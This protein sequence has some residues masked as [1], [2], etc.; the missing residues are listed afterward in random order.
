VDTADVGERPE[1]IAGRYELEASIGRGAFG[2]VFRARDRETGALVALKRLRTSSTDPAA[3]ERFEREARLHSR[4]TSPRIVRC[5]GHGIEA[6]KQPYLVL[7]WLDG[8]DVGLRQRTRPLAWSEVVEVARQ[9]ALGLHA[10]HEEG[11]VHRDVKPQNLFVLHTAKGAPL[12]LKL[13]D[14]GIARVASDTPLTLDGQW[15]GTPHYMSPEQARGDVGLGP[16]ADV[17]ALGSVLYELLSGVRPFRAEDP[18]AVLAKILLEDPAPLTQ[19]APGLPAALAALVHRALAKAPNERFASALALAEALDDVA[20]AAPAASLTFVPTLVAENES[21]TVPLTLPW[22]S[23]H[24]ERR[25]VTAVF[26]RLDADA[27][28]G[29]IGE[30]AALATAHGAVAHKVLARRLIAIFGAQRTTGDEVLRA[31]RASLAMAAFGFAELAIVTG[32]VL[33]GE[34]ELSGDAI[35]RGARELERAG[36]GIRVDDATARLLAGR[37]VVEGEAG[38][39]TLLAGER[40]LRGA[41]APPVLGKKTPTVGRESVLA[42]IEGTYDECVADRVARVVLLT[43][44]AGLGK[45][46]VRLE[47]LGRLQRRLPAPTVLIARAD[48]LRRGSPLGLVG[49]AL[50]RLAGLVEGPPAA[51]RH[52]ALRARITR[53][54][55][56]HQHDRVA[57]L[58]GELAGA[59]LPGEGG[60]ALTAARADPT[61]MHDGKRAAWEDWLVAETTASPVVLILEDLHWADP[62]S[63]KFVD[64]AL[65]HLADRPFFVLALARPDVRSVFPELWSARGVTEVRL[66]PLNRR[67]SELLVRAVLGDDVRPE[68]VA[69]IVQRAEGNAFYLEELMRAVAHG[70]ERGLPETVLGMVQARIDELG[71]RAKRVL[72]AASVFGQTFWRG[73]IRALLGEV[74]PAAELDLDEHLAELAACEL[75]IERPASRFEGETELVFRHAL[76]REAAYA[77]L[78][79]EDRL[80]AHRL[81]GEWLEAAGEADATVLAEHFDAGGEP[82]RAATFYR[83]GAEQ[84]LEGHDFAA[85]LGCVERA[86]R[87]GAKG[88]ELATLRLAEAEARRWR[89]ELEEAARTALA[90]KEGLTPGTRRWFHALGE[91]VLSLGRI[92]RHEEVV[93][94]AEEA[95]AMG[96]SP[97]EQSA[98]LTCLSRAATTLLQVGEYERADAIVAQLDTLLAGQAS[99]DMGALAAAHQ[100]RFLHAMHRGDPAVGFAEQ[101]VVVGALDEAGDARNG[102]VAR[103]NLAFPCVELGDYERA[104]SLLEEALAGAERVGLHT[105]VAYAN[106]NL[107]R[108]RLELGASSEARAAAEQA[109]AFGERAGEPRLT[110]GARCYLAMIARASG[111][112]PRARTLAEESVARMAVAPP[113][114]PLSLAVLARIELDL[115]LADAAL[116]HAEDAMARLL[117]LGRIEEGEALVRLVVAEAR[118]ANGDDEGARFALHDAARHLLARAA[119]LPAEQ[120]ARFLTRVPE[121]AR[122]L[123]LAGENYSR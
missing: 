17:F 49:D 93:R 92:G 23:Q 60:A 26:A 115:G 107:G 18:F 42:L 105:V 13:V 53:F 57:Q 104:Q 51:P 85:V 36:G 43:G 76:V 117:S 96:A 112:L 16:A 10:L 68:V 97:A 15:I 14:L 70:A 118:A 29:A 109:L 50:R 54:L 114:L 122:T 79:D 113:S 39:R 116:E 4:M 20:R 101:V 78:A 21:A 2:E 106:L 69:L 35:E 30:L 22:L 75:V 89:G 103:V 77:M 99:L 81:A 8:E 121:N 66:A 111:D 63:V 84:A 87:C 73:G 55:P 46:R 119:R 25:V 61:L 31:A 58:L 5:L 38:R 6:G 37:F 108:V 74:E 100:A 72:R 52:E 80:L 32:R 48:P 9:A 90:A 123:A 59:P 28:E 91:V 34:G 110:G 12:E 98:Q 1:I 7:E 88:G 11:V 3:L 24:R 102:C 83:R 86:L 94:A 33:S 62:P 120:R 71:P 64:A 56:L 41:E 67:A 44:A 65:R 47:A 45:S 40:I 82:E 19:V 95:S 27:G